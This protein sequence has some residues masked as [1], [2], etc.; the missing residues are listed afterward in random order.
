[1]KWNVFFFEM[2]IESLDNNFFSRLLW[3]TK[4]LDI[5]WKGLEASAE[6]AS[7][8]WNSIFCGGK[9]ILWRKNDEIFCVD[10]IES[11]QRL[12]L[13]HEAFNIDRS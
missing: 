7:S 10:N 2:K 1:M 3:N 6:E 9:K 4:E 11:K 12:V 13:G 5:A 8:D